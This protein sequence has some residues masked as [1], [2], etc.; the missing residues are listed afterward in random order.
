MKA[1]A[2][3]AADRQRMAKICKAEVERQLDDAVTRAQ[4][5]WIGSMLAVG[6]S[7]KTVA[8]VQDK[9]PKVTEMFAE[10]RTDQLADY[11]FYK[12]LTQAGCDVR[13]T[14]DEM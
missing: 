2:I 12:K 9:L 13:M 14:K 8:R 6:L 10:Y 4:Y 3:S 1:N 11:V 5:L 7:P